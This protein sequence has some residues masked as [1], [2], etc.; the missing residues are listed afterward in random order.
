MNELK[1]AASSQLS[2]SAPVQQLLIKLKSI[3]SNSSEEFDPLKSSVSTA[4]S[5]GSDSFTLDILRELDKPRPPPVSSN[6]TFHPSL[7]FGPKPTNPFVLSFQEP[8][9][10]SGALASVPILQPTSLMKPQSETPTDPFADLVNWGG[11]SQATTDNLKTQ[12]HKFN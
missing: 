6:Q 11:T 8:P 12:W 7:D 1:S 2:H 10:D 5:P 9:S 3:E 4:T